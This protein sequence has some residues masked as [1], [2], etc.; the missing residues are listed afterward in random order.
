MNDENVFLSTPIIAYKPQLRINR[1]NKPPIADIPPPI[2]PCYAIYPR[3]APPPELPASPY[4]AFASFADNPASSGCCAAYLS[5]I[6]IAAARFCSAIYTLLPANSCALC[7]LPAFAA[8]FRA[9]AS[10]FSA[11]NTLRYARTPS[12]RKDI[13]VLAPAILESYAAFAVSW[14]SFLA[15]FSFAS[16]ICARA[17]LRASGESPFSSSANNT[18]SCSMRISRERIILVSIASAIYACISRMS[19]G[20]DSS[21]ETPRWVKYSLY[22]SARCCR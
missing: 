10:A 2:S 7:P 12:S 11:F 3:T 22:A 1:E 15:Y 16:S 19:Y 20:R 13:A 8:S 5:L 17:F 21:S 6:P 18:R 9:S 14:A 4:I